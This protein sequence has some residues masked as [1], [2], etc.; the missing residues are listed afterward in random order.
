M[1]KIKLLLA[2]FAI[3]LQSVLAQTR[4]ITG[5]VISADDGSSIPG[6]SVSVKG[7]TLGTITDVNGT[8]I[9]K[10]PE[11]T[12][13][14][15]FSFVGMK[16]NEVALTSQSTY[17][18]K[19]ESETFGVDE[20]IVTGYGVARKV[21]F[22][23]AAAV[24]DDQV[25][26]KTTDA[27]PIR[28]L[29]G[30]VTG[31]QMATE[32][33]QPG[34]YNSV[35]IR[36]LGSFNSGTQPLYVIDGIPI[37]S[38]KFGMREDEDQT[39]NPLAGLNPNDIESISVLKDATATSI[40][41]ARAANGVIVINTK[42][43]KS[44]ETEFNFTAKIGTSATPSRNDYRQLNRKEWIDFIDHMA[45]N[46]GW[47]D[48]IDNSTVVDEI[49]S[50]S[51]WLGINVD[52]TADTDWYD[53]VTRDG[54]TQDYNLDIS[55]GNE[56]T[57][58]FVSGSYYDEEGIVIG[59]D[60]KRYSGRV[61]LE[62]KANDYISFGIN[63]TASYSE[64][65]NGSGGGYYSDPITQAYM[66]LPVQPVKKED[67]SWNMDTDN[68]YN[69]VAQ[70]SY[71]GDRSYA[72]QYKAIVSPW[73]SVNFLKDF[74]FLTRYGMDYYN[75]KEFGRWSLLQP[76]G[77]DMMMLGEEGNNYRTLWTWT[78]TLNWM[79]SFDKHNINV[80]FGE[81][82]QKAEDEDS[83]LAAT[84]FPTDLVFT[85]ENAAEPSDTYTSLKNY[86][87]ASF[88]GKAEYDFDNTYYLSASIRRDGS[89]RF[90]EN[91]KWATFW[92]VG[93]KYRIINESFM[94]QYGEWLSNLTFRTSYGTTGN[95]D[96]DWYQAM[97][98]YG[99]GY[100]Y[101]N[102]PGMV[103]TQIANPELQ[104]EQ[105]NKFNVGMEIGLFNRFS[106][107]IDFYIDK[108]TDMLFEVPLSRATGFSSVMQNVGE[109][110]NKGIEAMLSYRALD[111]PKIKWDVSLNITH[112]KNEIVKLST[113]EPI[114]GTYTIREA[115]HPYY[116]FKMK[117]YAGVDSETGDQLWYKGTEGTETT[118]DYNEAGKRYMGEA[119]PKV[120]GGLTNTFRIYDFDLSFQL[121]YSFG[122]KLYNSAARYDEN[123]NNPW[124]NTTKYVYDNMWRESG[125]VTDVP[126]PVYGAVTSHSS[127]F[128]MDGDFIKLKTIQLGYTLPANSLENIGIKSLRVFLTGDNVFTWALSD[129]F[130]G[131]DPEV[132]E[133]GIIWWNYPI[134]RKFMVGVN[135]KF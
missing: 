26:N 10:V 115:G 28:A 83:Y 117:E 82:L 30:A 126:A 38:G 20:V 108:T 24:V 56:K 54:F 71:Y 51:D 9:I 81:E 113:D 100:N 61:N 33:G 17:N 119:D 65:N 43:G 99:F 7:T 97:G 18:V 15:V 72:Q 79:K 78:N 35:L 123:I 106:A 46:S 2:I 47:R 19:M 50:S 112:N 12:Q 32:T 22:T 110:K 42:S 4:E 132:G 134:S 59:K 44:G 95:Q 80:L 128:L 114:E 116:T 105:T 58:F 101:R 67:G 77:A 53:E 98:L 48:K 66:Q 55:G 94:E 111:L 49:I 14:L 39:I 103:P 69:P 52:P 102:N 133:D 93:A 135:V 86:S 70:R 25:I 109:M 34:G 36:G 122:G 63:L 121:N 64:I 21:A 40:Y 92:S 60:M 3:G 74:T 57:K 96:V 11:S 8:F 89:S 73:L 6:V 87:L 31:V 91:N 104:W 5:T 41:G 88:F 127:R 13:T 23:G 68:G 45:Y 120:Y 90:G 130:R 1:K 131:L 16:T 37:T 118:S 76:Q 62:N 27:D 29:Q 129:S 85:I 124:G 107:D 84:N 75:V 125:D